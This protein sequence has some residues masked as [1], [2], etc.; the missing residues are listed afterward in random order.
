MARI[1][2]EFY[3]SF[4]SATASVVVLGTARSTVRLVAGETAEIYSIGEREYTTSWW[5]ARANG[6]M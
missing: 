1:K 3:G 5:D 2:V 6:Y 4:H